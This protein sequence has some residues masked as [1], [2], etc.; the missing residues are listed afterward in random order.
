M[1]KS[2]KFVLTGDPTQID[3]PKRQA[4]GLI[5]ALSILKDVKDIS[6]VTFDENDVI[7]HKLVK[8]II[9]AYKKVEE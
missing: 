4:S 3:L 6:T 2:A 9:G 1:G 5:Q 7:R 8:A